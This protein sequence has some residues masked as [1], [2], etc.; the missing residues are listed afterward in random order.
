MTSTTATDLHVL[1]V[2]RIPCPQCPADG[3]CEE[4][5]E[6]PEIH[7][8]VE[9]PGIDVGHCQLWEECA[10]CRAAGRR[11]TDDDHQVHGVPHEVYM[12]VLCVETQ[13]CWV[14]WADY[15]DSADDVSSNKPGRYPVHF[16]ST[17]DDEC[18]LTL[19]V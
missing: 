11:P 10:E 2:T 4:C 13:Q 12:D 14:Q 19:A 15:S 18:Y 9:C 16:D 17:Y 1:V 7:Y 8:E 6:D 5:A 3:P